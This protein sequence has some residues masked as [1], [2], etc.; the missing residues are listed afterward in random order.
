VFDFRKDKPPELTLTLDRADGVYAPGEVIGITVAIQPAK[1][2]KVRAGRL[3]LSGTE[4]FQYCTQVS[5]TDADGNTTQSYS[6]EWGRN[7]FYAE[8]AEFLGETTLA[9]S[10]PERFTFQTRLPANALP[11]CM[12]EILRVEWLVEVKLDRPLAG[13]LNAKVVVRVPAPA[14]G[15]EAQPGE[16]GVSNEP[17]EAELAL[18]LPGLEAV[19]GQPFDGQLRILPRK[20]F[21][22]EVRLELVRAEN[23]PLSQGHNQGKVFVLKLAGNTKFKAGQQQVIAFR[24]PLPPDAAPSI[25]TEHG[26]L[27]W[28]MKGI[29]A[30][31]LRRDTS[32]TQEFSVFTGRAAN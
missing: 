30:R 32:I 29:L 5:T 26:A 1:D 15:R 19:A 6:Y 4:H 23:V 9:S 18:V 21:G 7:E 13:D 28:T 2:Y 10:T 25:Q 14:P 8:E 22:A 3:R 17:Q 20:D 16:Y 31:R 12:G 11:T 24:A 27:T